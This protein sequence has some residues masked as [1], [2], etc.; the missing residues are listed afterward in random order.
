MMKESPLQIDF[1]KFWKEGMLDWQGKMPERMVDDEL[2]EAFWAQSIKKK[3]YKQIDDYAEK[4]YEKMKQHIPQDASCMEIGPGW[5]NYT[6]QLSEDVKSL[7]LVDG[8]ESVLA[9]L[10]QYYETDAPVQF[11]YSKWEEAQIEPHDVVVGVNCFYRIYE[12]K[13]ALK[14]MNEF[15]KKRAIIGLTTGPIQPHYVVLD[16]QYGY[17]IKYPR[18][19]YI[20]ILNIL[21]QLGIYA[22]CEMVKLE[23]TYR[24]DTSEQLYEAQSKKILSSQFEVAHV[25]SS[26]TPFIT[27]EDDQYVYRHPFY[28]AIISWEPLNSHD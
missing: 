14:K 3:T 28:A 13:A 19:D 18:R 6:F 27:L 16:K 9:Y 12:M 21:Y 26:L 15:A 4:I 8:S 5:G 24:Y 10:K 11:V 17:K 20:A 25:K 23:R 7:T 1:E 2:E 22:D